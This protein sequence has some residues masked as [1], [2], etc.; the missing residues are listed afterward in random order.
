MFVVLAVVL[1]ACGSSSKKSGTKN[2]PP[3]GTT[4]APAGGTAPQTNGLGQ[5]VTATTVKV[6]IILINFN[7]P[8]ISANIDFARG[9]QQKIFQTFVDKINNSG[10]VAGGKKIVPVYDLYAPYGN[11]GPP[12]AVCTKLTE[13]EH[14]YV[15][16]GVIIEATGAAQACFTKQHQTVL[17]THELDENVMKKSL[18]G[19]L[20][21]TDE[22]ASR[23]IP[24]MISSASTKGLL[25][26]K[27]FA[28]LAVPTTKN[29]I[30]SDIKPAFQQANVPV[31]ESDILQD[32]GNGDT[33]AAQTQLDSIIERWKGAGVNGVFI[34]GLTTVAKQ[35]VD[36]IKKGL[37]DALLMTDAD[38]SAKGAGGDA[39]NAHEN[40]NPYQGMLAWVGLSDNEQFQT[41]SLQDCV[42]TYQDASGATVTPP[43]QLTNGAN[44]KRDEVWITVRDA[45]SDLYFF[46]DIA[47]RVGANL[48]NHNW[49][50]TV[51][52]YGTIA[53]V[54]QPNSS[55][56]E[57]KYDA[58]DSGRLVSFDENT[59]TSGDWVPVP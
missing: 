6:G 4:P 29:R 2:T 21:T 37:P 39:K 12:L 30:E 19:L 16:I 9:D 20:L 48:N 11:V 44:G 42:K 32:S 25:N 49:I 22:L 7:D 58:S 24:E 35:F 41:Q 34:S 27:K 23:S 13:D 56:H 59:G 3:G 38:S 46:R 47:N 15:A 51:N 5:G 26:G 14:V 40:P 18:D 33:T 28:I 57:G 31:V 50:D 45:C 53:V 43:S 52:H 17:I 8:V 54:A 10:G 36:K 55:L 1:A